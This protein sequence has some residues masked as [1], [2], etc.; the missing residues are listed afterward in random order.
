MDLG[1]TG[2]RCLVTGASSG[3]G[4]ATARALAAEGATVIATA[5]SESGL[6]ELQKEIDA[7]GGPAA[8][9]IH[10]DLTVPGE[11][12]RLVEAAQAVGP[13][14]VLVC[15][16]GGSRPMER[17]D[18]ADAWEESFLLNF[19]APRQLG[20]LLVPAMAARGW[21]RMVCV[22]GA[23]IAKSFNAAS[24][25]KAAL[26][27]W[28]KAAASTWAGQGV[29]VNCVAPGRLETPQIMNRL[30]RTPEARADFAA[31]N[32]PAGRFGRAEDAADLIAF[33]CSDRAGYLTGTTIPIDGAMMRYAW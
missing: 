5:R 16:A 30:H 4:R 2:R 12:R 3:I 23:I 6:G 19:E 13:V 14:D 27:S 28:A 8:K 26:E 33:L 18:D 29:T 17:F 11:V 22:S 9:V 21:G 31:R 15:N 20:E 7:A 32:I 1:L 10:A 25:A 24:P